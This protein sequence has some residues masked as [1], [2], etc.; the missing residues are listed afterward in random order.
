MGWRGKSRER[1][2]VRGRERREES[3]WR[4]EWGTE[5][6]NLSVNPLAPTI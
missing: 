1:E 4:M 2:R 3:G 5:K 6:E